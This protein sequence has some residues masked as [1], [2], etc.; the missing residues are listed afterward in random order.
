MA[1]GGPA[2]AV[3]R[4]LGRGAGEGSG[5]NDHE[6]GGIFLVRILLVFGA[7]GCR[8]VSESVTSMLGVPAKELLGSGVLNFVP[9]DDQAPLRNRWR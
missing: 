9:L 1:R 3:T 8:Y 5:K 4:R 6:G 7:G 2:V